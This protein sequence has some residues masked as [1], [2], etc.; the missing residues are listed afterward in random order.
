[1]RRRIR[2]VA[3]RGDPAR[4]AEAASANDRSATAGHLP[5]SAQERSSRQTQTTGWHWQRYPLERRLCPRSLK[6]GSNQSG[7]EKI[8]ADTW[9]DKSSCCQASPPSRTR[10]PVRAASRTGRRAR[11]SAIAS[12]LGR[13]TQCDYRTT[14]I[15]S[16]VRARVA[17]R[18][19]RPLAKIHLPDIQ[20]VGYSVAD[21]SNG[22]QSRSARH[23]GA[24]GQTSPPPRNRGGVLCSRRGA[25]EWN[26]DPAGD[27]DA[28]RSLHS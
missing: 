23:S 19:L 14:I 5:G 18:Y 10:R 12:Q 25:R 2:V 21:G 15:L 28:D 17:T 6:P 8:Q 27:C 13:H 1:M 16:E 11:L 20:I 22:Q 7:A 9:S 3:S 4:S 24:A 26:P